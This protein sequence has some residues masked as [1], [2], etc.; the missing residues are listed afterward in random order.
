VDQMK[1]SKR[2]KLERAGFQVGTVQEFLGLSDEEMALIDLK[3]RLVEMLK[4]VRQTSGMT[5]R[6]LAEVMRSSQ[7]RIAKIE[8]ADANVSLDLICKAL[9]AMGVS[10]QALGKV[11][12]SKHAA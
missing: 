12:A 1:Q 11:I 4:S 5:Q 10:R 3:V 2:K 6:R 9:F 8:G 7:S